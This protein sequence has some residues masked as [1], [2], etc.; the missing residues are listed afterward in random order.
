VQRIQHLAEKYGVAA[1]L[2]GATIADNLE[3]VVD[4]RT[5]VSAPVAQL[6]ETWGTALE[7]AL[8]AETEERLV[9]AV[10]QKS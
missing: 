10:L 8:H 5:V 4:G 6:R 7:R 9:P 3:I 1:G 2:I